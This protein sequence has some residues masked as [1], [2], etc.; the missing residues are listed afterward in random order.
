[1]HGNCMLIFPK[2]PWSEMAVGVDVPL[3]S[4]DLIFKLETK[5]YVSD[6]CLLQFCKIEVDLYVFFVPQSQDVHIPLLCVVK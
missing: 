2:W 6:V 3:Q 1:M 4:K 5:T